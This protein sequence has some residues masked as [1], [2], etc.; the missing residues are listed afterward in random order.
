MLNPTE[1]L[2]WIEANVKSMRRSPAIPQPF[3]EVPV[4]GGSFGIF[5]CVSFAVVF[6]PR[7]FLRR[8]VLR[9]VQGG[10]WEPRGHRE[11][12]RHPLPGIWREKKGAGGCETPE[13]LSGA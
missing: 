10:V 13:C 8:E 6:S 7:F 4:S 3:S 1:I 12:R 9:V 5:A 2:T 11:G